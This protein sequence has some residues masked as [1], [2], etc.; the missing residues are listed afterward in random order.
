MLEPL[1]TATFGATGR[2][3]VASDATTAVTGDLFLSSH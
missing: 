3:V 1:S 2:T